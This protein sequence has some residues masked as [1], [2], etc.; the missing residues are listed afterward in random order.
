MIHFRTNVQCFALYI[1]LVQDNNGNGRPVG[2]A[3][4][5]REDKESVRWGLRRF[6]EAAGGMSRTQV[7]FVDKDF[8][9][10]SAITELLP[11]VHVLLCQFHVVKHLKTEIARLPLEIADKN[12][13]LLLFK[14][15]LHSITQVALDRF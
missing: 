7:V 6:I 2:F 4:L 11:S 1:V 3:F 12:N 8:N 14:S 5:K 15:L 9:E 13:L 10:I